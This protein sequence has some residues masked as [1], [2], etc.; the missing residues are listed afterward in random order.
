M[1]EVAFSGLWIELFF[2]VLCIFEIFETVSCG[3]LF[4][5]AS[6]FLFVGF[7]RVCCCYV[8]CCGIW[9]EYILTRLNVYYNSVRNSELIVW[10]RGSDKFICFFML[11]LAWKGV[12]SFSFDNLIITYWNDKF[13]PFSSDWL[14]LWLGGRID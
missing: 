14:V 12:L 2:W 5:C 9:Y 4:V 6:C 1:E 11:K 13:Y 3:I 8:F 10:D 7:H